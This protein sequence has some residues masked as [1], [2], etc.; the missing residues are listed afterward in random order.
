[1]LD[2]RSTSTEEEN[3]VHR[4]GGS[5]GSS[6]C[7]SP[8]VVPRARRSLVVAESSIGPREKSM[9]FGKRFQ[10][11]LPPG[12]RSRRWAASSK[13]VIRVRIARFQLPPIYLAWLGLAW[14]GLA[15]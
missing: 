4:G 7:S 10:Q 15:G 6:G 5:G 2:S 1:M 9:A 3:R 14:L 11:T 13:I 12:V 8:R